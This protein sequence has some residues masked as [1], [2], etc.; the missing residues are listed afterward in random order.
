MVFFLFFFSLFLLFLLL[1]L[2][3]AFFYLICVFT[4]FVN[5]FFIRRI[6][7][8][9]TIIQVLAILITRFNPARALRVSLALLVFGGDLLVA[10]SAWFG[11]IFGMP[12]ARRWL[13]YFIIRYYFLGDKLVNQVHL[14][15]QSV[16][17]LRI[18]NVVLQLASQLLI[19]VTSVS[20]SYVHHFVPV[21]LQGLR[22]WLLD[23]GIGVLF[24][25][26][27]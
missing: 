16:S 19:H 8:L 12:Q 27:Q 2:G 13:I 6:L 24:E 22:D 20:L 10:L 17:I 7:E 21:E 26:L 25:K 9:V 1:R 4:C 11:G 3:F 14:L 23:L 18:L 15:E 5:I